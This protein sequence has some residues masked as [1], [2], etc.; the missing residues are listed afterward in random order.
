MK[1]YFILFTCFLAAVACNKESKNITLVRPT[2]TVSTET[3]V[4]PPT[5]ATLDDA[6]VNGDCTMLWSTGDKIGVHVYP[7]TSVG[8]D[9][10]GYNTSWTVDGADNGKAS[11]SFTCD[12]GLDGSHNYSYAAYYP[13]GDHNIGGD[14]NFYC[15]YKQSY[16]GYV[17]GTVIA[18]MVANMNADNGGLDRKSTDIAL[19]HVGAMVKVTLNGVPAEANKIVLT[20]SNNNH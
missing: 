14:A 3:P 6:D 13:Y 11:G 20:I 7:G 18:P 16:D 17:P 19:K 2:I 15:V 1:K 5:M 10:G 12:I 4:T 8:R 9:Y